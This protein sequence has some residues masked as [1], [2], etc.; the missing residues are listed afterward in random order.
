MHSVF[1]NNY[2]KYGG[3]IWSGEKSTLIVS[4]C[5]FWDNTGY[6]NGDDIYILEDCN[7][8][9]SDCSFNDVKQ[10]SMDDYIRDGVGGICA[11]CVGLFAGCLAGSFIASCFVAALSLV[12]LTLIGVAVGFIVVAAVAAIIHDEVLAPEEGITVPV[13]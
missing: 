12:P 13:H 7:F 5:Q 10:V 2:A 11:G 8:D 4:N 9:F 6:G 3:A 1:N